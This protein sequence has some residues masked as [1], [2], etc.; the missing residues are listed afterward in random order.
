M[1]PAQLHNL[2]LTLNRAGISCDDDRILLDGLRKKA[3]D[4]VHHYPAHLK[5]HFCLIGFADARPSPPVVFPRQ[6]AIQ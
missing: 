6:L 4:L 5:P 3:H 1:N 2:L